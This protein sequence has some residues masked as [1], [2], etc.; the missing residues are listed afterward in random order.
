MERLDKILKHSIAKKSISKPLESAKICFYA[1]EWGKGAFE[2]VSFA[3][4]V[5]KVFVESSPAASDLYSRQEEL[6]EYINKKVGKKTV[7]KVRV[8]VCR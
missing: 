6:A 2:P 1:K 5:L 7:F 4:G 8:V 3:N